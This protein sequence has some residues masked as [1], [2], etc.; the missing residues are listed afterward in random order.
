MLTKGCKLVGKNIQ[1][2]TSQ[3]V[4]ECLKRGEKLNIIDVR[5]IDEVAEGKILGAKHISLGTLS[6]RLYELD[7]NEEYILVCRSGARS[8]QACEFLRQQGFRVKNMLGGMLSW[9]SEAN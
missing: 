9:E 2:I 1:T 8:Q 6:V 5:E 7:S 3:E 4:A